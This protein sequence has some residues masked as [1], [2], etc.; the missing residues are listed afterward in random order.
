MLDR[1]AFLGAAATTAGALA[2]AGCVGGDVEPTTT[3]ESTEETT[4][5]GA[6][7]ETAEG[8]AEVTRT[9]WDVMPEGGEWKTLCCWQS[10]GGRCLNKGYVVD[11][12]IVRQKT[13]DTHEDSQEFPQQRSCLK[14]KTLSTAWLGEDRIKYPMKRKNW[15]PGGTDVHPELRGKDEWERISWDEAIEI[16]ASEVKRVFADY[17]SRS[18]LGVSWDG[19]PYAAYLGGCI[20]IM[21]TGSRGSARL[22][23]SHL[24]ASYSG[25]DVKRGQSNDRFDMMYNSENIVLYSFNPAWSAMGSPMWHFMEAKKNGAAFTAVC[26]TYNQ[27][28]S[29]L[30]ADWIQVRPGTDTAF[31]LAVAYEMVRLDEEEGGIVD[32]DF[33]HTYT[34]GFDAESMPEDAKSDE[35][36][37]GY[38]KG[39]YDGTPK[40]P[41]W[42]TKICGTPVDDITKFARLLAKDNKVMTFNSFA[43]MRYLGTENLEQLMITVNSM[44][45][46]YGKSGHGWGGYYFDG[47]A[48][49]PCNLILTGDNG[50]GA[51]KE[52]LGITPTPLGDPVDDVIT[53]AQVWDAILEGKFHFTG[54]IRNDAPESA[55]EERECD[56]RFM[57]F[58]T[59]SAMRAYPD[60]TKAVKALREGPIECVVGRG[61][62]PKVDI[63]YCDIV[64]PII[65]DLEQEKLLETGEGGREIVYHYDKVCDPIYEARSNAD[66]E[67]ALLEALGEDPRG[68]YALSAEQKVFNQMAGT[69]VICDDGATYE[70]LLSITQE[71]IDALG[72]EGQPQEGRIPY[73]D[74][75]AQGVYQVQR[76]KDDNFGFI[77]YK[78]FVDDPEGH[79][80]DSPSGKF[81][82]YC[83]YK[84][85]LLNQAHLTDDEWKPYPHYVVPVEGYETTF[86][87]FEAGVKGDYPY[88]LY[89]PHFPRFG[90]GVY[91]NVKS[92]GEAFVTPVFV[93]KDVAEECGIANG[94]AVL[95]ESRYGKVVR[96]A[97]V[98]PFMMPGVVSIPN[99]AWTQF[100]DDMV[101]LMGGASTL[102][103]TYMQGIG[104]TMFNSNNV[105]ISKWTGEELGSDADRQVIISAE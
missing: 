23:P 51:A 95:V 76:S 60:T 20:N 84:A 17:G 40:T 2:L 74:F 55:C 69:Q 42:A 101:D 66:F 37:L 89:N 30:D 59:W 28:A 65:S 102:S 10:C 49:A 68:M 22:A 53:A 44:G 24:G 56:I 58:G 64:L 50:E 52:A 13:D 1:R 7:T 86:D 93:G 85:D 32:W 97:S 12:V 5:N 33:L 35:N 57:D 63:Q 79:P 6:A 100:N 67:S 27:S 26:P 16:I 11:G 61:I 38:I 70:N 77:A 29:M 91:G 8:E 94:D 9:P 78:D 80:L 39:E 96:R 36:F 81:E 90:N 83:Q 14:G 73:A 103:G 104:G 98:N 48:D 45:G 4:D 72:V 71:D 43:C 105:R 75:V 41:E 47:G 25:G 88:Q 34:V 92:L 18:L 21:A 3:G 99:G 82:I 15:Q 54:D 46:H 31:L 19:I 87:D 62:V